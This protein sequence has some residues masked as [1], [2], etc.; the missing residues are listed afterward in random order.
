MSTEMH[1]HQKEFLDNRTKEMLSKH[2]EFKPLINKLT[3]I[4][5]THVLVE[6]GD[7]DFKRILKDGCV[8]DS[9]VAMFKG[10]GM[11]RINRCHNNVA[12]LKHYNPKTTDVMTGYV[13]KDEGLWI[14]HSWGWDKKR[15]KIIETTVKHDKYYGVRL[16][17]KE[18]DKF[19]GSNLENP[20]MLA[21][22]EVKVV[23]RVQLPMPKTFGTWGK[24]AKRKASSKPRAGRMK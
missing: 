5:G 17:G 21:K 8:V 24:K 13:L 6:E 22:E 23:K 10:K 18:L 14:P 20:E 4:D 12:L 19:V 11:M 16:K 9:G 3:G 15:G 1:P 7:P 2:P